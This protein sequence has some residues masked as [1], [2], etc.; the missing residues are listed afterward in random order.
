MTLTLRLDGGRV[1]ERG[2]T[3]R[4]LFSSPHRIFQPFSPLL[5]SHI[6]HSKYTVKENLSK[7]NKS[8]D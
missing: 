1:E 3:F 5:S 6:I 4:L 8:K 2:K 7:E